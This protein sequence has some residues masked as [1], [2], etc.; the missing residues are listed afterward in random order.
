MNNLLPSV[1]CVA[2]HCS[3]TMQQPTSTSNILNYTQSFGAIHN[4][5]LTL[6]G[7]TFPDLI[8]THEQIWQFMTTE[9]TKELNTVNLPG[10]N[11]ISF[12]M[13]IHMV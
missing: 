13:Q 11:F 12:Q 3:D 4:N 1:T 9:T 10:A 2:C 8:G 5:L 7:E 6:Y